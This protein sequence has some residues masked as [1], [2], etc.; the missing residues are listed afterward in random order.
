[1][2]EQQQLEMMKE[3]GL[4]HSDEISDTLIKSGRML[5]AKIAEIE[6]SEML[7]EIK[8]MTLKSVRHVWEQTNQRILESVDTY[9]EELYEKERRRLH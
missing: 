8:Q 7:P 9:M 4:N 5:T 1:M 2:L 6:D 3:M